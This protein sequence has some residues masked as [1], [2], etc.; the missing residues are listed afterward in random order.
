MGLMFAGG[1]VGGDSGKAPGIASG[2]G[3][4]EERTGWQHNK[5]PPAG[6]RSQA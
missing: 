1:Q 2:G 5:G 3:S 6:L 4:P